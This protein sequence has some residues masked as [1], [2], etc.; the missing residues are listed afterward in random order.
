MRRGA[1]ILALVLALLLIVPRLVLAMQFKPG[2]VLSLAPEM[3]RALPAI[4]QAHLDAQLGRG[5]VVTSARDGQH[6]TG[7]LHYVGLAVD[8]RANDLT[9]ERLAALVLALRNRLNGSPDADR[10]FQVVPEYL[11][12]DR[13]HVHVEYQPATLAAA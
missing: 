1:L 13:Q 2:V 6:E 10:P 8:L 12:T 4:E 5:A 7:S 9:A 3:A 11:G